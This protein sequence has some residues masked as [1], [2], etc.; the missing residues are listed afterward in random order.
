MGMLLSTLPS[1]SFP[2]EVRFRQ[3]LKS[4]RRMVIVCLAMTIVLAVLGVYLNLL[5]WP[6]PPFAGLLPIIVGFG[7]AGG[8]IYLLLRQ[9]SI[10][11]NETLGQLHAAHAGL[12]T[13]N[14]GLSEANQL[15][16]VQLDQQQQ[17]AELVTTLET[18]A[19][20]LADGVVFASIVGHVDSR[21]AQ[22][23]NQRL[24]ASAS[25]QRARLVI[26]DIA[27]VSAVDTT[28]ARALLQIAQALRLLGCEVTIS[29]ISAS[30]ALTLTHLGVDMQ[31]V[32]TVR[33]PQDALLARVRVDG[34]SFSQN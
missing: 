4:M 19:V 30:A 3:F 17:L 33:S 34:S 11:L 28:V 27:G 9:F 15:L 24:L 2:S 26:I 32:T 29:G 23:I 18:S 14:T 20:P 8:L 7:A 25:Q 6:A 21:R 5:V 31:G 10:R 12:A 16:Q 13:K 22:E 1:E